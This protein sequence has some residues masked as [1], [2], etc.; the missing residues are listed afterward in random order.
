MAVFILNKGLPV[1]QFKVMS[2]AGE[3]IM[4]FVKEVASQNAYLSFSPCEYQGLLSEF[5]FLLD[6]S[7]KNILSIL[8]K[9]VGFSVSSQHVLDD[10]VSKTPDES[11]EWIS[12]THV[13]LM[14][15][16]NSLTDIKLT[17]IKTLIKDLET[18]PPPK[19]GKAKKQIPISK[20]IK[21]KEED[22][23]IKQLFQT[24]KNKTQIKDCSA[25]EPA[26]ELSEE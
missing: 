25:I 17:A 19:N 9:Y 15:L 3:N 12:R 22:R 16:S 5:N 26:K 14:K 4:K 7:K 1:A 18:S 13:F 11:K 23:K 20:L 2:E 6:V 8:K 10:L 24:K 21:N